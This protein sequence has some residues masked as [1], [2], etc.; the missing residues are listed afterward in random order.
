MFDK[1][2][3]YLEELEGP[4]SVC[5]RHIPIYYYRIVLN[6]RKMVTQIISAKSLILENSIE[7]YCVY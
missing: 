7:M 3:I 6:M 1:S 2:P 4:E 5:E